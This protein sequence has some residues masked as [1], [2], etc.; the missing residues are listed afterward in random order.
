[1]TT[2]LMHGE[3]VG[4]MADTSYFF[5]NFSNNFLESEVWKVFQRWGRILDIFVSRKL[6]KRN[7]R[8][9]FVRFKGMVDEVALKR[10]LDSIWIST[11]KLQVNLSRFRRSEVF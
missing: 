6:N 4:S 5:T 1:M 11:W 3:S 7:R 9:G 8:F 2:N 10:K